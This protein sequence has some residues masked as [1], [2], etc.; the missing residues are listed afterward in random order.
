MIPSSL[1]LQDGQGAQAPGVLKAGQITPSL[2]SITSAQF[3]VFLL[4]L[5]LHFHLQQKYT[6]RGILASS[7]H[8]PLLDFHLPF[9]SLR[10]GVWGLG[11]RVWILSSKCPES[12]SQQTWVEPSSKARK[13]RGQHHPQR[14]RPIPSLPNS[15]VSSGF[16]EKATSSQKLGW[17]EWALSRGSESSRVPVHPAPP[18]FPSNP[19]LPKYK[20][21]K[22][23]LF[24]SILGSVPLRARERW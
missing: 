21:C 7:L 20:N 22:S 17:E 9:N 11:G 10:P 13:C 23:V 12:P 4:P 1:L 8:W 6:W 5:A 3:S 14:A 18:L 19:L 16:K 2:P 24:P 15:W